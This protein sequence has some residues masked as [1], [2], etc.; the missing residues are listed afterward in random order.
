MNGLVLFVAP[1]CAGYGGPQPRRFDR[2]EGRF[3][4]R[5]TGGAAQFPKHMGLATPP[6]VMASSCGRGVVPDS[7][8]R[9]EGTFACQFGGSHF[10]RYNHPTPPSVDPHTSSTR[11]L[12]TPALA[13]PQQTAPRACLPSSAVGGPRNMENREDAA[14]TCH[15][16]VQ[17]ARAV[18][19]EEDGRRQHL[20]DGSLT[21]TLDLG[22]QPAPAPSHAAA[23]WSAWDPK[24][25]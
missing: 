12:P 14:A 10:M 3:G 2:N 19:V 16:S 18:L 8:G 25:S 24:V 17:L 1:R 6:A 23:V 7:I 20:R 9:P 22:V 4:G 21:A 13:G 11:T 15:P 5:W